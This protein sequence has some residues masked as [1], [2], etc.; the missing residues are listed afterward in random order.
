MI[1]E[2]TAGWLYLGEVMHHRLRPRRHR[3]VYRVAYLLLDLDRLTM[4]ARDLRLFS[5]DRP[6]LVSFQSRDH[7]ARDGSPLRPWVEA[8]LATRGIAPP[9]RILLLCM[10]RWL[11]HV[12]NPLSIYYCLDEHDRPVAVVHEV[13]NIFGE[14]HA[15]ALPVD[16]DASG[17]ALR[18]S[19][20]KAFHVSPFMEMAARY[21]FRLGPPGDD[22]LSVVIQEEVQGETQ[23][24][25][26]LTGHRRPLT[27]R[28]LLWAG[29]R[30]PTHKVIF[31]IHWEALRLWLGG[32]A[33]Q[34]R[35]KAPAAAVEASRGNNAGHLGRI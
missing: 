28:Q 33:L 13:K 8:E 26:S 9:A 1:D 15:Y 23:L 4:L 27:D 29:L 32:V 35:P 12:F 34:P 11:G 18:Q 20:L 30:H 5:V 16:T 19:C 6:N 24:V 21:R 2:S 17:R 22:R 31:G 3:F 25:A 7:G 10:P 14:Q